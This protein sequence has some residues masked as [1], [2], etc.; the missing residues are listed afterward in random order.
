[1]KNAKARISKPASKKRP[2]TPVKSRYELDDGALTQK[3]MD[4]IDRLQPPGRL[5]VTKTLF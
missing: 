5:K 3:Q 1:M 2:L 4:Q